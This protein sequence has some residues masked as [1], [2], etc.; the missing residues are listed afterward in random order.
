VVVAVVRGQ[1]AEFGVVL[2]VAGQFE[3]LLFGEGGLLHVFHE[4]LLY[5]VKV[6]EMGVE[7]LFLAGEGFA[8][9]LREELVFAIDCAFKE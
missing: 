2:Q 3:D 9:H 6:V 8:L 4:I 5:V 7:D 1:V